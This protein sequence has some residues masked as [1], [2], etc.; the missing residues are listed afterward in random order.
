METNRDPRILGAIDEAVQRGIPMQY[1]A[2]GLVAAGWP[3]AMVNDAINEWLQQNAHGQI[4]KKTDFKNWLEKYKKASKKYVAIMVVANII[5]SAIVLVRPWPTKILADS[6]FGTEKAPWILE[7]Y[8]HSP[9]L[10]LI[11][12]FMLLFIFLLGWFVGLVKDHLLLWFG[13]KINRALKRESFEHILH[14]P[15][16]HQSRLA[17]GDYVYRQNIVT[18]SMADLVLGTTSS[19]V[20]SIII[21]VSVLVV[22]IFMS[23]FLTL[24][25]VVL[26]PF[27][28]LIMRYYGPK[29][30]K[31]GRALNENMSQTSSMTTESVDNAETVQA[32]VLE[33]AQLDRVDRL[34]V[35]NY[36]LTKQLLIWSRLFRGSNSLLIVL[37]T[38]TVMYFGGTMALEGKLSLGELLIFMT[39]MGYLLSPIENLASQFAARGQ[40]I[41][42]IHRVFEVLADHEGI[43]HLRSGQHFPQVAGAIEFRN[44]SYS[45]NQVPVLNRINLKINPGEKVAFIGPS[46]G[47]KS[48]LLKLLPQFIEPTSGQILISDVDVQTISLKELRQNVAWISQS[49]QLFNKPLI[50]NLIDGDLNRQIPFEEVDHALRGAN[51]TDFIGRLPLGLDTPSG[52]GGG[53]LSGGQRQRVAIARALLKQ[54]PYL[55]MDEPTAALDFQSENIIKESFKYFL[56]NRTVLLVTH[57]RALLSLMDTIYVVDNGTIKNVKELGGL[58]TYLNRLEG[59]EQKRR[60]VRLVR[61]EDQPQ[62]PANRRSRK[63]QEELDYLA[64]REQEMRELDLKDAGIDV[65]GNNSYL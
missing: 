33:D 25:G 43:E 36:Q 42:D 13:F 32:F 40:K 24:I 49:P 1:I 62:T 54:A 17:K 55:A 23:P 18:N 58:T 21:I 50:E 64:K 34:W 12:S 7:P 59:L 53:S 41:I 44:V 6:G 3:Q 63:L 37:G 61:V 45:Y 29:V 30:A 14:L 35:K 22:M 65:P 27:I 11:T 46:G 31:F 39:Y 60:M 2:Y 20:E 57:R 38:S 56:Q 51:V 47:G 16:Y 48:T 15:L 10:I 4:T 28:Y 26:V 5:S 8:T 9:G 52:E 19:I